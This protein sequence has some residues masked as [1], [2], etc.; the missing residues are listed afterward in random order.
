MN[1]KI[2]KVIEELEVACSSVGWE[3]DTISEHDL[4]SK[5]ILLEVVVRFTIRKDTEDE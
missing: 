3:V 5:E 1:D 4:N 2:E